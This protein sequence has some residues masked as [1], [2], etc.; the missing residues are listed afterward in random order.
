VILEGV[1]ITPLDKQ[2]AGMKVLGMG[3]VFSVQNNLEVKKG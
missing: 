1:V 2:V 3:G